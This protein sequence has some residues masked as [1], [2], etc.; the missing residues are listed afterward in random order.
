MWKRSIFTSN[1]P[2]KKKKN[3]QKHTCAP[4]TLYLCWQLLS[5]R[6]N[7]TCPPIV[8][9]FE[10]KSWSSF[11]LTCEQ[12]GPSVL[13]LPPPHLV[14]VCVFIGVR[15]MTVATSGRR[16]SCP[17][18]HMSGRHTADT[19]LSLRVTWSPPHD[20]RWKMVYM[21]IHC[22]CVCVCACSPERACICVCVQVRICGCVHVWHRVD[23]HPWGWGSSLH[24]YP[25]Q[26]PRKTHQALWPDML[27]GSK[28]F[29]SEEAF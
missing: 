25:V 29:T 11:F 27:Y 19:G 24:T 26:T 14:C 3:V 8:G 12:L 16:S 20:W 7:P 18:P 28:T 1:P 13:W 21:C 5:G 22:V 6:V 17:A 15:L 23:V 2:P 10:E 4:V 9:K